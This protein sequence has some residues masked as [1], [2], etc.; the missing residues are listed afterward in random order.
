MDIIHP[1]AEIDHGQAVAEIPAVLT[2]AHQ[3]AGLHLVEHAQLGNPA[4]AAGD[5]QGPVGPGQYCGPIV[6][7]PDCDTS[8]FYLLFVLLLEKSTDIQ[9][10]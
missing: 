6:A 3:P 2:E 8:S 7:L 5:V 1:A 4:A 10:H 9:E